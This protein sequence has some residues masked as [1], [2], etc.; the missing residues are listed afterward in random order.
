MRDQRAPA[1]L[2]ERQAVAPLLPL[3]DSVAKGDR[4]ELAACVTSQ[5]VARFSA[6]GH[7]C[8]GSSRGAVSRCGVGFGAD[9]RRGPLAS[10]TTNGSLS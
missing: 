6:S 2:L 4:S 5:D 10:G 9:S 3:V 8:T 1:G 7:Y